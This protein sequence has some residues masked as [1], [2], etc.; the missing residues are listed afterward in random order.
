MW[1]ALA[2]AEFRVL[3]FTWTASF[4]WLLNLLTHASLALEIGYPA[5]IWIKVLR[6]LVIALTVAL[7]V[8]IGLTA[9]GLSEFGL[10]M[11]AGNLAFVSGEWLRSL[12]TGRD[13]SRAAGKVLYDGACPKCRASMALITAADPDR[14]I[15]PVDLTA[16]DVAQV[17]PSLTRETCIQAMHLVRADGRVKSGYDAVVNLGAWLPLF[18][19]AAVLGSIPGITLAGRRV[20]A[21]VAE[22]RSRDVPCTDDVC[23]IHPT[24]SG[25]AEAETAETK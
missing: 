24:R 15:E 6:P 14:V 22:S 13:A 16:V 18:W 17:H 3:D 4:P 20:Y 23:G 8:G 12:V 2:S 11:I 21:A 25:K 7:H 19:P 1:G 5:L 10:A 9:P